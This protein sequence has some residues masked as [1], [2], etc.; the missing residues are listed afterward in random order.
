[1]TLTAVLV[2]MTLYLLLFA[3]DMVIL[4]KTPEE[5]NDSLQLLNDYCTEWSLE[6]N[7]L[8]L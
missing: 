8:K 6:V 4:G 3:D 5:I 2:L 7:K 1:M